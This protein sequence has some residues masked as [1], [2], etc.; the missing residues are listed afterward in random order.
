MKRNGGVVKSDLSGKVLCKPKKSKKGQTPCPNEWQIDHIKP[1]S[2]GGSNSYKNAQV[3]S[4][5]ENR[6]KSNKY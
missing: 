1:K 6:K 3:L 5:A 2:K 4:R